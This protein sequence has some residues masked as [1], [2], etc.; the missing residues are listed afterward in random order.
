MILAL[1]LSWNIPASHMLDNIW[2]VHFPFRLY[3]SKK[4]NEYSAPVVRIHITK[5]SVFQII[6]FWFRILKLEKID[7]KQFRKNLVIIISFEK[8]PQH[9]MYFSCNIKVY[10]TQHHQ[11]DWTYCIFPVFNWSENQ[12]IDGKQGSEFD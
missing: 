5:K 1:A 7:N 10:H 3:L 9:H 8:K 6:V 11:V 4:S 12:K 2:S